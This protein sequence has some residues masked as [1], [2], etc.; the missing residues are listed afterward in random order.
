ME[1]VVNDILCHFRPANVNDFE[2]HQKTNG[3]ICFFS[4][5]W[6]SVEKT[7]VFRITEA[8]Q[9]L[10]YL[11]LAI[12]FPLPSWLLYGRSLLSPLSLLLWDRQGN[13]PQIADILIY[14]WSQAKQWPISTFSKQSK[15]TAFWTKLENWM[16]CVC[17]LYVK[18]RYLACTVMYQLQ[19][20]PQNEADD[21]I[22]NKPAVIREKAETR[23]LWMSR[24]QALSSTNRAAFSILPVYSA[25]AWRHGAF[26]IPL[27]TSL[28]VLATNTAS[29]KY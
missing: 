24:G 7:G 2:P 1:K 29:Q 8:H 10:K 3:N 4:P 15:Q 22:N 19:K 17:L 9:T 6:Q 18:E 5:A 11:L 21:M 25:R 27:F 16:L 14:I 28:A 23:A 20:L 13:F 12:Y 26:Y